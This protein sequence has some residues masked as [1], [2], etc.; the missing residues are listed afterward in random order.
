[1]ARRGGNADGAAQPV[2][3][4]LQDGLRLG[5]VSM[6]V[7]LLFCNVFPTAVEGHDTA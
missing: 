7:L 1:M 3:L 6:P 4:G 5:M 2:V